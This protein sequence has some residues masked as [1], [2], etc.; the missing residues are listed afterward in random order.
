MTDDEKYFYQNSEEKI[1]PLSWY[2]EAAIENAKDILACGFDVEKTFLFWDTDYIGHFYHNVVMLQNAITYNQVK[3][4]F[5]FTGSENCG[6]V[7][8]GAI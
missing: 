3:G 4:I 8:Y 7:A 5:G 6:K 2:S 1:K